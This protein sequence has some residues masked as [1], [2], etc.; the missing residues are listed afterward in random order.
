MRWQHC[1]DHVDNMQ[2]PAKITRL[3]Y[4]Q[5]TDGRL[6]KTTAAVSCSCYVAIFIRD[7]RRERAMYCFAYGCDYHRR[8][9]RFKLKNMFLPRQSLSEKV[10]TITND[11]ILEKTPALAQVWAV[12]KKPP[13]NLE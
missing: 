12:W 9:L 3:F 4:R 10:R 8:N 11:V 6:S 1:L 5:P 2:K 13:K 7:H